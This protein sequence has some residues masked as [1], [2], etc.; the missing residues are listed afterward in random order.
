MD[1]LQSIASSG[2]AGIV[3]YIIVRPLVSNLINSNR[4]KDDYIKKLVNEHFRHDEERHQVMMQA[5][6]ELPAAVLK[7][8]TEGFIKPEPVRVRRKK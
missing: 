2:I 1:I 5:L 7:T 6:K 8:V 3:V 4:E